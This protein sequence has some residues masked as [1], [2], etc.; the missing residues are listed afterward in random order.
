MRPLTS[1]RLERT[2]NTTWVPFASWFTQRWPMALSAAVVDCDSQW[3]AGFTW[4]GTWLVP[5]PGHDE[6]DP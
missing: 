5:D 2:N 1:V 4:G 3:K 6:L